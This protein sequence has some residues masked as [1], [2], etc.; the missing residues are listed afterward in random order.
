MEIVRAKDMQAVSVVCALMADER[1]WENLDC[2]LHNLKNLYSF[3]RDIEVGGKRVYVFMLE[4]GEVTG[5][6]VGEA[7]GASF[8]GHFLFRTMR[9]NNVSEICRPL[10]KLIVDDFKKDGIDIMEFH[11]L[12][13]EW[14]KACARVCRRL[15][16]RENGKRGLFKCS[17]G[18]TVECVDYM[19]EYKE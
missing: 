1:I 14:N 18:E 15:G 12:V 13:P 10:L 3:L 16:A 5:C 9:C 11:G 19:L 4:T 2:W 7:D 17:N 8:Y 6:V